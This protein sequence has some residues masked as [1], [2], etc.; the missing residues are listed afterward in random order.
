V[1]ATPGHVWQREQV[2]ARKERWD[3]ASLDGK[4]T[5]D[6]EVL[7]LATAEGRRY[8]KRDES[9]GVWG[10][11]SED[12]CLSKIHKGFADYRPRPVRD[13]RPPGRRDGKVVRDGVGLWDVVVGQTGGEASL[14]YFPLAKELASNAI[15]AFRF[16][17]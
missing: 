15:C 5:I 2:A 10:L 7:Q 1:I 12:E 3:N 6:L 13:D 11:P 8:L 4:K 16:S 9:T 14:L 17:C